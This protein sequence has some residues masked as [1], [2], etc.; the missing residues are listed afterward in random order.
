MTATRTATELRAWASINL[1]A[2][3][4]NLLRARPPHS[5]TSLVVV[6]KANAYGHGLLPVARALQAH[7]RA[8]DCFGVATLEEG[9]A[10]REA[11]LPH[12]I[13]LLEGVV[14]P[15]E[16]DQAL[17]ARLQLVLH[18]D[19]QIDA[20]LQRLQ[21]GAPVH[22]LVLWLKVDTGMHRLGFSQDGFVKAWR[23]L[24]GHPAVA[25]LRVMT[26]FACADDLSSPMT[27]RQL[28]ALDAMLH[29][30]GSPDCELSVAASAAIQQ[31]PR[32]HF[33]WL[34]PGIMLYGG[35]AIVAENGEDRGLRPVMTLHSRIMAI[36]QVKAG[37][38]L[39]YGAG[40]RCE[41]DMRIGIV[42]IGYGDGYPRHA[43]AGTPVLVRS[44]RQ[45]SAASL[46]V[47]LC[48]R[49]SM[50][51]L[52]I[53]LTDVSDVDIGDDVVLWGEGLP[54]DEIARLCGT[55]AYELF[56]QVTPRV[57]YLYE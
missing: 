19:Y 27:D 37:E 32:A 12:D 17:A 31:W 56:C 4:D 20:L 49:V 50:D 48:G 39:G 40:Y 15:A 22:P 16:L 1:Q 18:S 3:Q 24:H 28:Q 43:P 44:R 41:R 13:V 47:P 8:H 53:D 51:M 42:S 9:L 6:V 29:A 5:T 7:L 36:K 38:T 21:R 35:A 25:V 52:I 55:I 46:R 30:A 54:A 2:L 34:R 11:G 14:T 23:D 57:Q 45:S 33:H 26:H 10:L